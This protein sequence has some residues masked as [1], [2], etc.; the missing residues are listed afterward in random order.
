MLTLYNYLRDN[1][2]GPGPE[3]DFLDALKYFQGT[4]T[5]ETIIAPKN[6][7]KQVTV[8]K[9]WE[10]TKASSDNLSGIGDIAESV[11]K[12]TSNHQWKSIVEITKNEKPLP[13]NRK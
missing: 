10:D 4:H 13:A 11:S 5:W 6:A 1:H 9:I 8:T 7:A 12:L 2:A 3:L